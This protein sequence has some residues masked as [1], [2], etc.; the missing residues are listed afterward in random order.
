MSIAKRALAVLVLLAIVLIAGAAGFVY[1]EPE[2]AT[3][4][5]FNQQRHSAG[6]VRKEVELPGGLRCVYLEG[7]RGE[8]LM[9]I[10]GFG[11]DKDT[12]VRVARH[13]TPHYHLIVPDV[14]GFGESAHPPA[15]DYAP[16]AQV[17][18]LRALAKALGVGRL[19]LGG[20]SMG[21]QIA[22]T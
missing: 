12:F 14:P 21:G 13:L 8:P 17:E 7:G 22:M 11:A 19:H 20:N 15:A 2:K 16:P 10:H 1:L 9:L 4:S 3:R 18:R 6:L 5:F